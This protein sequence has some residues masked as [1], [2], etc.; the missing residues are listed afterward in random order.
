MSSDNAFFKLDDIRADDIGGHSIEPG[1]WSRLDEYPWALGYA[2]PDMIVADMGCG[3]EYRPFM[4]ALSDACKKVY[5]VDANAD[6]L[7][8]ER[9]A[10]MDFIVSNF[11]QKAEAIPDEVLDIV[12]CIS[13]LEHVPNGGKQSA[14]AEFHRCL[15]PGGLLV[16]TVDAVYDSE[17]PNLYWPGANLDY[18]EECAERVGFRPAG[19]IDRD[20]ANAVNNELFNLCVFHYVLKRN[21]V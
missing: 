12:F 8:L 13:T 20:K 5:A 18:I 2:Q 16:M 1:W 7:G 4:Y 15:K 10:N 17:K 6:L 3:Y 9:R 11:C 14:L 19:G 21:G